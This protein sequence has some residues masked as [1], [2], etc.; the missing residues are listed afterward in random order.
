MKDNSIEGYR[1]NSPDRKNPYNII[2]TNKI[3]MRGVMFPVLGISDLGEQIL[4]QPEQDYEFN[5]SSVFEIPIKQKGGNIKWEIIDNLPKAQDGKTIY[6]DIAEQEYEK[7]KNVPMV[8]RIMN[9]DFRSIDPDNDNERSTHLMSST[10][11]FIFPMITDK[12]G[13]LEYISDW[14]KAFKTAR[15]QGDAIEMP[16]EKIAKYV[17]D[18][19]YK[20]G[21]YWNNYSKAADRFNTLDF[22]GIKAGIKEVESKNGLLMRN[23]NSSATG[24]YGQ[25][26]N[27]IKHLPEMK[28]ISRDEFQKNIPL[29]NKVFETR[30]YK[31]L[32]DIPALDDNAKDLYNDYKSVIEKNKLSLNDLSTLSN[33]LGRGGLRKYIENVLR[34]GKDINK[35]FPG[36]FINSKGEKINKTPDEYLSIA[37]PHYNKKYNFKLS[38][39]YRQILEDTKN[40]DIENIT[41]PS[42]FKDK[43][44][45]GK[46]D[47][48]QKQGGVTWTL[49]T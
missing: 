31:G 33:L 34:D 18:N 14:K 35:V 44:T 4:M 47:L 30:F 38:P 22:N 2:R 17:A 28:G 7:N 48:N 29:Q 41:Y 24:Y 12:N 46:I 26:Y 21:K 45:S 27:E 13:R 39:F 20:Q 1:K 37:R 36:K 11:K 15:Q 6:R 43:A 16:S 3:S 19:G 25:L 40:E 49:L 5:G 8:K 9:N 32:K 42:E 10:D 23:P